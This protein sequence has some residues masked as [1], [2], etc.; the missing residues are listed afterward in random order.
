MSDIKYT[1]GPWKVSDEEMGIFIRCNLGYL[2]TGPINQRP[3]FQANAC[4][5]AAAPDLLE[6]QKWNQKIR[7]SVDALL[8]Q[9]GFAIDSSARNQLSSMSFDSIAKA[10]GR[11]S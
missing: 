8:D 5:I 6:A 7:D 11:A 9:A 2:V 4:L 1:P 3:E 10:E